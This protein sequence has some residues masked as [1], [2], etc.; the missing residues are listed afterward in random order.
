MLDGLDVLVL[1]ALRERPHPTHFSLNE[2]I[3]VSGRIGARRTYFTHMCHDL[4]HE[5]TNARLP[6]GVELA[7]DGLVLDD[8][9]LS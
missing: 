2:A 6:A 7:Y 8:L 9:P 3:D 4:P 5:A 1:D